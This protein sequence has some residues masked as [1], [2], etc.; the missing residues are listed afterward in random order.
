MADIIAKLQVDSG[1]F[2]Q[3]LKAAVEQMTKMEQEVRRTGATFAY[4]DKEELEFIK[5]LG[6][7]GTQASSAKSKMREYSDAIT[8]LTATYRAM[9][10]EEKK[11]EPGK[12]LAASIDNLKIKAAELKDIMSDTNV[13]LRN[14]SSDTNFTD[15]LNLMTRTLGSCAAAVTAWTGD[16]KEMEAVI[17]D[18][19]KIGTTVAAVDA[20]TKAFQKQNLVLLKNPY[21]L[22]AAGVAAL[23]VAMGKLIKKSQELS[24]V[25]KDLQEVQKKGRDDAAKEITRI[26][27]LN[28][29]LHDNTRSMEDRNAALKEIKALVPEY[30]GALT[31]E[32]N[33]IND[34]TDALQGYISKLQQAATAQAAF[35]KMVEINKNKLAKQLELGDATSKRDA[36]RSAYKEYQSSSYTA[37]TGSS[38]VGGAA[39]GSQLATEAVIAQKAVDDIQSAI[40][41]YDDQLRELEKLVKGNDIAT[42]TGKPTKTTNTKTSSGSGFKLANPYEMPTSGTLAD[43]ERQAAVV[44]E[45][46]GG[47]SNAKEYK[48]MEDYLNTI[49]EKIRE[50]KGEG[51]N[52]ELTFS[53]SGLSEL[54]KQIKE[55]LSNLEFGSGDYLIATNNLIDFNTLQTLLETA[56]KNG[57][58][59]DKE[60]FNSLFEDVKIGAD[61]DPQVWQAA[62][63]EINRLLQ[64]KGLEPIKV[65]LDTGSLE[66]AKEQIKSVFDEIRE[67]LDNMSAGVGAISTIGNAFDDLK[68]IGEDLADAFSGEMDAW[69]A[70]M[71]VFN[72]GIGI[73]ETVIG[74]MEAINTLQELSV[75]LSGKKKAEQAAE[76]AEVVGGKMAESTANLTEAGTSMTSAGANA[77][78]ASAAA[79]KSVA[80]I[81]IVGPILA[82]AAIA[83]VLG[84]VI[85]AM[86]KA[87]SAGKFAEGGVVPGNS[88]SGDK[89]MAWVNSGETVLTNDQ[90]AKVVNGLQGSAAGSQAS[91]PYVSGE[92]IVLGVNNY[93][94]R[95]GQ[96]EV[97]TTSMLRRA[98]INL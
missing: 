55:K 10:D 36:A 12:A 5:S 14:L 41:G 37:P 19:A 92:N 78:D 90:A 6:E 33:L 68:N 89:L 72:S 83:A 61:V 69:D 87:K 46:M 70:L 22:A 38:G 81:P 43:L 42:I 21:V 31:T 29:I 64:E 77:A 58:D 73:M 27:T 16:G 32:G 91:S 18:L 65:N 40:D 3:K 17:K 88:Y 85:G 4:A 47:A 49:L 50:I 96:G 63:D 95:S 98:G 11:S 51:G 67:E 93:L 39:V 79:G 15:G 57:L 23:A 94:G 30:H 44:R 86:S 34:N 8:S 26:Q 74:V 35:D 56:V 25:E 66:D 82:V 45:S 62:I 80:G 59:F 84:A 75:A 24:Q 28:N 48:E 76:T 13:E 60:W 71:T 97:V 7:M 52:V 2:D 54:G 1:Q 20:L 9:T 53:E